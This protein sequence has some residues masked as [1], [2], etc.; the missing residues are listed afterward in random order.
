MTPDQSPEA[1]APDAADLLPEIR[2]EDAAVR[3]AGVVRRTPLIPFA[4]DN[5]AIELRIKAEHRQET[6]SFKARG[7][8]NQ[9][10]A[11]DAVEARGGVVCTSSGNH[12]R[13]LSWAAR[14]AG[15]SATVFMPGDAYPN[16]IEACR[17][18]GAEVVLCPTREECESRC[19]EAVA[20]G[21]RL[22]HPYDAART[23][24]GAGTVGLEIA[25]D[26]PEVEVVIVPVGGGGL[27]SGTSLALKRRL[28]SS[29]KVVGAEPVGAPS[30][31]LGMESGA[32]VFL[33]DI[34]TAIQ[35]LCPLNSGQINI[36]ICRST[37]DLM[38]L[39]EDEAILGAQS[40]LVRAGEI[41]EPAGAAAVA[42]VLADR[43]PRE[44]WA[45]R[46]ASEPLRVAAVVSGGNADPRQLASLEELA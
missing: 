34:T 6:G 12:G 31:T 13:A 3:L 24:E 37:V 40:R 16:K 21:A 26:W 45:G 32:P 44:W 27:I 10:S 7:A 14:R 23:L 9:I 22:I 5:Q 35:G 15:V 18:A 1:A 41:V 36:D 43:L 30:L 2:P 8:W 39:V 17:E 46:T 19:A 20:A 11:L 4:C 38:R 42:L 25:E 29:V 33:T 28:G